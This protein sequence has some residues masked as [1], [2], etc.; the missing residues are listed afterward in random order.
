M[1]GVRQTE[2]RRARELLPISKDAFDGPIY[3]FEQLKESANAAAG[4]QYGA[5]KLSPM[6]DSLR[7]DPPFG[8]ILVS[9]APMPSPPPPK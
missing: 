1:I 8:Q 4:M 6:F 5:L 9:L 3:A 7:G 2:G